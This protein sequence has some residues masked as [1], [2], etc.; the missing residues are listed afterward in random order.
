MSVHAQATVIDV[1]RQRWT[2]AQTLLVHPAD[3]YV[4]ARTDKSFYEKGD[5]VTVETIVVDIE[6]RAVEAEAE[7]RIARLTWELKDGQYQQVEIDPQSCTSA[8]D[9]DPG[10]CEFTVAAGGQW[11]ATATVTD[12]KGRPNET[13][14]TFWVTG[15][16]QKP[17]R[18]V[19]MEELTLV[20]D[21]DSWQ[22]G[23]TANILVISPFAP[24]EGLLTLSRD[25][26][27]E[28]RRFHMDTP[29]TTLE[30]PITDDWIPGMNVQID[31]VGARP[32]SD[33]EGNVLEDKKRVAYAQAA[34]LLSV[35]P[36]KNTLAVTAT[37]AE[38]SLS[39]GGKTT[40]QVQVADAEGRPVKGADVVLFAVDE[41]VLALSGYT[42][43]DPLSAFYMQTGSGVTTY[44]L[45][46]QVVLADPNSA[47]TVEAEKALGA[48]GYITDVRSRNGAEG[49]DMFFAL[50][51]AE[52]MPAATPPM[53]IAGLKKA[54][55]ESD[56]DGRMSSTG[57]NAPGG[58]A[59][60]SGPKVAVRED[61]NALAL[62]A[63]TVTTGADGSAT[64]T[65]DLPDSLTRYR[66]MAV[67][68]DDV[69]FGHGESSVTARKPLMLR[70]SPPRFLNFGDHIELPLVVQNQ[71]DEP[72]EV[73]LALVATNV[74]ITGENRGRKFTVPA[75]DRREIRLPLDAESAGTARFQVVVSSGEYADAAR[76]E[77]PVWTP[78]TSEAFA[79]YG[80]LDDNAVLLPV[81]RPDE[82]WESYGGLEITTSSTA[83]S[84]LT[85]ALIYLTSYPYDCSEQLASRV[86]A[87]AALRDVL[88]A[89]EAEQLPAPAELEGAVSRDLERLRKRQK[90]NGGWGFWSDMADEPY[91][92][93]HVTHSLVRAKEAGYPVDEGTLANAMSYL[94]HIESHIPHWYSARARNDIIAY[95]VHVRHLSGD[96]DTKRA[97]KLAKQPIN[98][99]L[100]LQAQGWIAP[101]LHAA[102]D[103]ATVDTLV[104]NWEDKVSETAGAAH[105]VT[106]VTDTNDYVLLNSSRRVDAVLLESLIDVRPEHDLTAK[107]VRGLLGHRTAGRWSTTQENSFVL[108][109]M[110]RFFREYESTEPDFV[111]R[112]WLGETYAGEKQFKGYSPDRAR[113]DVPMADVQDG[114]LILQKDGE[115]RLYYRVGLRY[116]PK[117]LDLEPA[118][119][120]FVVTRQYEAIDDPADVSQDDDGTWHIAAG[121]RVRVRL[122][123]VA[124]GRRTYV[125]LVDPLPA[126]LEAQNPAL[127]VTGTLPADP[128][129][130]TGPWW[131]WG[132]WYQHQNLRDER[133]EAFT[134]LLYAGVYE[135]TYVAV[136]TTPGRFVVPPAKAE[137]MYHPETFG[138][139]GTDRVVID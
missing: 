119:R 21:K 14:F 53:E 7:L 125:A 115:G 102:G 114:D 55:R 98:T 17:D 116:A 132:T 33:D 124:E 66:I 118:D 10:D 135:Y 36:L 83:L 71:T 28:T 74:V 90:G 37:P 11:R 108:L 96:S 44:H 64:V 15:E 77:L 40:I 117:D 99:E 89:F 4:G 1:N 84:A 35:P 137:E 26:L 43:P 93:V 9:E 48:L 138:R 95:S 49:G 122:S 107:V 57:A 111:A 94:K 68:A 23:D 24:A 58:G 131:W 97:R 110:N 120:G 100:S 109:A 134:T 70:P 56:K 5:D 87:V 50:D 91:L 54:E 13:T 59:A 128:A 75:N 67:A 103:T 34:M 78:A 30:I 52:D 29:S 133:A 45:R 63:P 32:R 27:V 51:E 12:D 105:F 76:F 73:E 38:T 6:G 39:P 47:L 16:E 130:N 126:G 62:W 31:V 65:L 18:S 139:T 82:V 20:P 92:T 101:T 106:G 61:F 112:A 123:M 113:L 85:D 79:T 2:D 60:P 41:S 3:W 25:G 8:S 129:A 136:A 80:E 127:A 46:S 19:A 22:P 86:L 69:N 42:L 121:A 88:A 81:K 72:M 104:R